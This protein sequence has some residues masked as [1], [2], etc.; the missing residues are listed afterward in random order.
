M[1]KPQNKPKSH[2]W[3]VVFVEDASIEEYFYL[4]SFSHEF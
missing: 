4:T 2:L 3:Y 1:S